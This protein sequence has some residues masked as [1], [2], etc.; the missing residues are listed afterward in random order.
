MVTPIESQTRADTE[1]GIEISAGTVL[2]C[3]FGVVMPKGTSCLA[4][5]LTASRLAGS[6]GG[7][8]P[9]VLPEA[10]AFSRPKIFPYSV[11]PVTSFAIIGDLDDDSFSRDNGVA[12]PPSLLPP[13][14]SSTL[15]KG[16]GRSSSLFMTE[17]SSSSTPFPVDIAAPEEAFFSSNALSELMRPLGSDSMLSSSLDSRCFFS[18]PSSFSILA[19]AGSFLCVLLDTED[20]PVMLVFLFSSETTTFEVFTVTTSSGGESNS[21]SRFA[22]TSL[23]GFFLACFSAPISVPFTIFFGFFTSSTVCF[24]SLFGFSATFS[25]VGLPFASVSWFFI[26]PSGITLSERPDSVFVLS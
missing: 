10:S 15:L 17:L 19:A 21:F 6:N 18:S 11:L 5:L 22:S 2:E 13:F 9:L 14:M 12:S 26:G 16:D 7:A 1:V 25:I 8:S 3:I 23:F 24:N 20:A 4:L